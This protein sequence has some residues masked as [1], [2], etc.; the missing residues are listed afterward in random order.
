MTG[1]SC[2]VFS[3]CGTTWGFVSSYAGELR[4]PLVWPQRY[5][6]SIRVARES[7][8]LLLIHGTEIAPQDALKG[9]SRSLFRVAAGNPGFPRLVMVTSGSFSGFLWE[10]RNTVEFGGASLAST[11]FGAMEEGLIFS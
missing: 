6:V 8:A 10:V 5:P 7:P 11:G 3:S 1:D 2:I 4:E 9:E